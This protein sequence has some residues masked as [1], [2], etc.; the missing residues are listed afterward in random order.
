MV[1][2]GAGAADGGRGV[3]LSGCRVRCRNGVLAR[4]H[5]AVEGCRSPYRAA[6]LIL[7]ETTAH[8]APKPPTHP[9]THPAIASKPAHRRRSTHDTHAAPHAAFAQSSGRP[10][11]A[12]RASPNVRGRTLPASR[13]SSHVLAHPPETPQA[14][15]N[16]PPSR[17]RRAPTR[18]A[19]RSPAGRLL[20]DSVLRAAR[21]GDA[22]GCYAG[23]SV[24]RTCE[25]AGLGMCRL[26]LCVSAMLRCARGSWEGI[27]TARRVGG[28]ELCVPRM[29]RRGT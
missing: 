15:P 9:T 19:L 13:P 24:R 6:R 11:R 28:C 7:I 21:R 10:Q 2:S 3:S 29:S 20:C 18:R 22:D 4:A 17:T 8:R 25:R 1:A 5:A 23:T 12:S 27:C 26:R 16:T 14:K